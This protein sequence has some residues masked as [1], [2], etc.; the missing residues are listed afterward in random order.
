MRL[1]IKRKREE[2]KFK[3]VT[4]MALLLHFLVNLRLL[5]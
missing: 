3:W 5:I 2:E 4:I 1:Q